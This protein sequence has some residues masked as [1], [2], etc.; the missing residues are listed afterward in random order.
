M[1]TQINLFCFMFLALVFLVNPALMVFLLL[2]QASF[3]AMMWSI[4]PFKCRTVT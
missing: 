4:A 2:V 3:T 1:R